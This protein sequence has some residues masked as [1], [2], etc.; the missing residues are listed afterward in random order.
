[1]KKVLTIVAFLH[2]L[3]S[4]LFEVSGQYGDANHRMYEPENL[5]ARVA[6]VSGF[7]SDQDL[8]FFSDFD[9]NDYPWSGIEDWFIGDIACLILRDDDN[10]VIRATYNGYEIDIT[11]VLAYE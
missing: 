9:G 6:V 4:T 1:M 8:V 2:V 3:L 7:D 5:Y 11:E 10:K